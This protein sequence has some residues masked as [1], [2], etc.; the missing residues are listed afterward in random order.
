MVDEGKRVMMCHATSTST[1]CAT[2][3][4]LTPH[5]DV[6]FHINGFHVNQQELSMVD[7]QINRFSDVL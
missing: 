7:G 1:C 5:D 3:F 2:S 4:K 6:S